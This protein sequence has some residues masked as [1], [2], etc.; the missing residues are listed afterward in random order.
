M[1]GGSCRLWRKLNRILPLWA[2]R[3]QG[4]FQGT[5]QRLPHFVHSYVSVPIHMIRSSLWKARQ[6]QRVF[7]QYPM[8]PKSPKKK[9]RQQQDCPACLYHGPVLVPKLRDLRALLFHFIAERTVFSAGLHHT[10]EK[11]IDR[12]ALLC[13]AA[14]ESAIRPR[15][16]QN[17][18][19]PLSINFKAYL[20]LVR[21]PSVTFSH[22]QSPSVTIHS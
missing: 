8:A 13:S 9:G 21:S 7:C 18:K 15:S 19:M 11:H 5:G 12:K 6:F 14:T 10:H 4:R 1:F 17:P 20:P 16:T 2:L 22:L 3:S